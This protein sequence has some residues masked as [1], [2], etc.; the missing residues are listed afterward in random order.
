MR[1]NLLCGKEKQRKTKGNKTMAKGS[2][3]KWAGGRARKGCKAA[4]KFCS[5]NQ[6][7]TRR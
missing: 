2:K 7:K 4:E 5:S 6:T 1:I 3:G